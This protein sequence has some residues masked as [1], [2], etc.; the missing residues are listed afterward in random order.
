MVALVKLAQGPRT[1][2]LRALGL[3]PG[4]TEEVDK[5]AGLLTAH[6][7]PVERL[8]TGVLYE[9][10]GLGTLSSGA[11]RRARA[12]IVVM[13]ALFGA[14]RLTD[15]LP[16]YRLSMDAKLPGLS[17]LAR[18]WRP[19]LE[20]AL[21]P[22]AERGLVVDL[23]S[24][25]Y[26]AAWRPTA[27][28]TDHTVVLRVVHEAVP[29]VPTSRSVVSHFNKAT[30]GRLLRQL[31]ESGPAPRSPRQL[32]ETLRGLGFMVEVTP[33]DRSGRSW[34]FDAVVHSL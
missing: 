8:Y 30:K 14:V 1:T 10:L 13:S 24:S 31:L 26:A 28:E 16:S 2:A 9:A 12:S 23:R 15:R 22:E 18:N 21:G 32:A 5:D 4:L 17:P 29:G 6:V 3:P 11:R 34:A 25:S 19:H 7:L 27:P 20:R 33:P